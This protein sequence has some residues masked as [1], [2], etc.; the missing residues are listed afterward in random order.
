[1]RRVVGR[2]GVVCVG[3]LGWFSRVKAGPVTVTPIVR[4]RAIDAVY[5]TGTVEAEDRV[6]VKAKS[7][8]SIADVRVKEGAVV[9]KGDLLARVDNPAVSFDLR[10]GRADLS[11]ATAQSGSDAPQLLSLRGQWKS[12][13]ADL[14]PAR[15]ELGRIEKL[16]ATG[17]VSAAALDR[18][19][20]RVAGLERA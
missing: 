15:Q 6:T 4:G 16:V 7:S 3:V 13:D 11:A 12:A 20:A 8:G 17:S 14:G 19:G 18:A 9:K 10:R 5:A 2:G 1:M